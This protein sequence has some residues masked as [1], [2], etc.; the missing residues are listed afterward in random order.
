MWNR[1]KEAVGRNLKC[2]HLLFIHVF[3]KQFWETMEVPFAVEC[4]VGTDIRTSCVSSCLVMHTSVHRVNCCRYSPA[5]RLL[6]VEFLTIIFSVTTLRALHRFSCG[7]VFGC[8]I[9]LQTWRLRVRFPIRSV[10]FS[11]DEVDSA[12]SSNEYQEYSWRGKAWPARGVDNL[13]ICQTTI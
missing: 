1:S 8:G 9:M 3:Y 7:S 4:M 11:I 10:D 2:I 6:V 5:Q 13:T 12:S